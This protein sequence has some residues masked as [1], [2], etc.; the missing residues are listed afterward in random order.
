M[1]FRSTESVDVEVVTTDSNA[2]VNVTGADSLVDGD[3]EVVVTV[4]AQDGSSTDY[5]FT[6]KV[7]GASKDTALNALTLNGADV[8]DGD[9]VYLPARTVS[10]SI[11][12][13]PRDPAATVKIT[14]RTGLVV[15][16]N[17]IKIVVTAADTVTTRT[18]TLRAIVAPLSSNTDL[19][20]LTV[21]G[22]SE[23][24]TSELQSH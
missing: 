21:N 7:G 9:I 14:G 6:V 3:N 5:T 15:G 1:L 16:T 20:K 19:S 8:V 24:H 17:E 11:S 22:R 4:T 13:I 2:S 10:V 12:A 18:L 23:E